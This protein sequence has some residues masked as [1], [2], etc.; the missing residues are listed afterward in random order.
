MKLTHAN[1]YGPRA[2]WAYMSKSQFN[3][4]SKCEAATLAELRGEYTR[5]ESNAFLVGSYVDAALDSPKVLEQ[6]LAEHPEIINSR[7]KELKADFQHAQYMVE[8]VKS[9]RLASMLLDGTK[10][11][12]LRGKIAGVP[13]RGKADCILS[14]KQCELIMKEFPQTENVLGGIFT[15]G[16]IVD[17]KTTKDFD[18]V[19]SERD[20]RKVSWIEYYGYVYQGAIY[21]ELYRQMH[22]KTLPFVIVAVSKEKEP[23]VDAFSIP[24]EE[25]DAGLRIVEENAPIY[26]AVKDGKREPIRCGECEY[27]RRTKVLTGIRNYKE[28]M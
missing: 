4:W 10:Q 8:R 7:T 13:F 19:W 1:Y 28:D 6:F 16:C 18:P 9:S 23:N 24:P 20:M 27:C 22:G 26:Q 25:L 15:E 21:R 12:I 17:L 5:P 2:N 14:P 11:Y 3:G